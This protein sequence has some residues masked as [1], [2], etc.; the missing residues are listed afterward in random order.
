MLYFGDF[1]RPVQ[2]HFMVTLNIQLE[3]GT[4]YTYLTLTQWQ[5]RITENVTVTKSK[6]RGILSSA[7]LNLYQTES[8]IGS[9]CKEG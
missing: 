2:C 9:F 7:I 6:T 5:K 3:C 4:L 1:T 8:G